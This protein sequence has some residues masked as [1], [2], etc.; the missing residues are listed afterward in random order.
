M[1]TV[2]FIA[3]VAALVA[4]GSASAAELNLYTTREPGLMQPLLD[5]YTTATGTKVN[6]IF[7]KDGLAERVAAEGANAPADVLM[8]VDFGRLIDLSDKG[9][10]QKVASK[11][12]EA[13]VPAQ[14]RD[15]DGQWFGL[16]AR[17][18]VAY[19]SKERLGDLKAL[20]YEEL[21]DP[22]YKGKVCIRSGQHPYNTSLI[23]AVITRD[24]PEAAKTWLTGLKAN[25]AQ[26]PAGGDRDGARDILAGVCDVAIGNSYYVGLMLSG[27]G[28]AEQKKWAEAVNVVLPTFAK[29]GTHV[30][31]SGAAVAKNAP[32]RDEA[33]RFLE[34]LVSDEA[35]GVFAQANYEYPIK[36]GAPVDPILADFGAL[37]ADSTPL[38]E[39]AKNRKAASALVD[40]VGFDN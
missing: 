27:K 6:A 31:V 25:L 4:G 5:A 9:L 19:V 2:R 8:T 30:N 17:A 1:S 34:F 7:I 24:G 18:R 22:K 11:T 3:C 39:I 33:V 40:Q 21:A 23:A 36:A 13:A 20:T 35:Q 12:L 14:F 15:P 16:S 29:G 38:V 37:K 26:K 32:N 28:G 10:T